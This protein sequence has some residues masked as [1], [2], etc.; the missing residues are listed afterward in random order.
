MWEDLKNN[1]IIVEINTLVDKA[2]EFKSEIDSY[3]E[4]MK[5][6]FLKTSSLN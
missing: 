2:E 6:M 5:E 4:F 3:C 1:D